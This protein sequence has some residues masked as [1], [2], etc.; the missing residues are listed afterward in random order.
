M[1]HVRISLIFIIRLD[2]KML[3]ICSHFNIY[4]D[5]CHAQ[6][7]FYY[8]LKKSYTRACTDLFLVKLKLITCLPNTQ[9]NSIIININSKADLFI[10][11]SDNGNLLPFHF[12]FIE[13]VRY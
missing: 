9:Y 10:S 12:S 2:I 5:I 6:N 3:K 7:N 8:L 4:E 13:F 11:S 1:T